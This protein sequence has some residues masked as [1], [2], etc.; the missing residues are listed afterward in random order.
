MLKRYLMAL[1]SYVA[2]TLVLIGVAGVSWETFKDGGWASQFLDSVLGSHV[3]NPLTA[4]PIVIALFF[5]VP[6]LLRGQLA[7]GRSLSLTNVLLFA[8]IVAGLHFS[9]KWWALP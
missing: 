5:L 3:R 1:W 7:T 8:M 4:A 9:M 2:F 6:R